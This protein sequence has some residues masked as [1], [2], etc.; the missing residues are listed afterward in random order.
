MKSIHQCARSIC[1][2]ELPR[3]PTAE[4]SVHTGGTREQAAEI[5]RQAAAGELLPRVPPLER[6]PTWAQAARRETGEWIR[7]LDNWTHVVHLTFRR[8]VCDEEAEQLLWRWVK[9]L[10]RD[11][12]QWHFQV[13]W[14]V[15]RGTQGGRT[16]LHVIIAIRPGSH[17]DEVTARNLWAASDPSNGRMR[18]EPYAGGRRG[19]A[20]LVKGDEWGWCIA[21]PRRRD[22]CRR[23]CRFDSS[24]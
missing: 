2:G 12:V 7:T 10:V 3:R 20:Y 22:T 4:E 19:A 5:M 1:K 8:P 18:I 17:L 14:A 6:W 15:E 16:H 24:H 9:P 23:R 11:H 21:C 13:A